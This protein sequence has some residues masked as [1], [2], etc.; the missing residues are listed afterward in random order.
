MEFTTGPIAPNSD[1]AFI[2]PGMVHYELKKFSGDV[3]LV[4]TP[5][6]QLAALAEHPERYHGVFDE[7]ENLVAFTKFN[8]WRQ[9]DQIAFESLGKQIQ[10]KLD[11][12]KEEHQSVAG[13]PLGIFALTSYWG[14]SWADSVTVSELLVDHVIKNADGREIRIARFAHNP[15]DDPVW[16]ATNHR[17]FVDSGKFGRVA[18][19]FQQ[20][21]VRPVDEAS[22]E[23]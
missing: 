14:L 12:H 10:Y 8:D 11:R 23:V 5:E 15:T 7:S 3:T 2:I 20:L 16:W 19:A 21:A 17:G 4:K 22:R 6:Q 18:G 13:R 9:A 1:N